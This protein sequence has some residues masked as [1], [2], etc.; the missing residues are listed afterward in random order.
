MTNMVEA[1]RSWVY[2]KWKSCG[3]YTATE[4]LLPKMISKYPSIRITSKILG[5]ISICL[6]IDYRQEVD[7]NTYG[8]SYVYNSI[9]L[10]TFS[11][12]V[13]TSPKDCSYI[14][15]Q[16]SKEMK[17]WTFQCLGN[18]RFTMAQKNCLWTSSGE[19][20][21]LTQQTFKTSYSR[22]ETTENRQQTEIHQ[23]NHQGPT[24]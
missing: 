4:S 1:G 13:N 11:H 22:Q 21:A 15:T 20:L 9:Q 24:T 7:V 19:I 14:S 23:A 16:G 12:A 6:S 8:H 3:R 18:K 17:G 5:G 10:F 2:T